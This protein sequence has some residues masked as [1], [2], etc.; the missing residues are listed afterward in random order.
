[1]RHFRK[2]NKP[3]V[4]INKDK[5]S[6]DLIAT[7]DRETLLANRVGHRS[8]KITS[9]P[10]VDDLDDIRNYRNNNRSYNA[11][12]TAVGARLY[13]DKNGKYPTSDNQ[14]N[15]VIKSFHTSR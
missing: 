12:K 7:V 15:R 10:K 2:G 11:L 3:D 9:N 1:M 8:N 5:R 14:K 6:N 4:D 13:K